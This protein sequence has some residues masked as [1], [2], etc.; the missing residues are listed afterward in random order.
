MAGSITAQPEARVREHGRKNRPVVLVRHHHHDRTLIA[1]FGGFLPSDL[2]QEPLGLLTD[3]FE[4]G[5]FRAHITSVQ[6]AVHVC[7]EEVARHSIHS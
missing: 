7:V 5:E 6:L 4:G 3:L 1:V 2:G